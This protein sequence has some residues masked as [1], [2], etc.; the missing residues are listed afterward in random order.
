VSDGELIINGATAIGAAFVGFGGSLYVSQ[1]QRKDADRSERRRAFVAYLTALYPIVAELQD[2]PNAD[3]RP[4]PD[5][6]RWLLSRLPNAEARDYLRV[7]AVV[8]TRPLEAGAALGAAFAMLQVVEL[9][10]HVRE[11]VNDANEYVRELGERRTP[12]LLARW[13]DLRARLHA[14]AE[15]L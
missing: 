15:E 14:M 9:P 1:R 10:P 8:G 2:M 4:L 7:R 13:P 11:T 3:D 12:E 6:A 5:P